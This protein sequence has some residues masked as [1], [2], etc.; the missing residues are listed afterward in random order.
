MN[1]TLKS[2]Q[3]APKPVDPSDL[4]DMQTLILRGYSWLTAASYIFL[5]IEDV[6]HAKKYLMEILPNI[7]SGRVN[8]KDI[9]QGASD[10]AIHIAFSSSGLRK[11]LPD[12]IMQTFSREFLEGMTYP[13]EKNNTTY[14]RSALLGD[15]RC[16]D[17]KR[18][19]WGNQES[20]VDCVLM[21]YAR[22]T[23]NLVKFKKEV[24]DDKK[25]GVSEVYT[26]DTFEFNP[27]NL[28]EHFGFMDGISQP[29]LRRIDEVDEFN[30]SQ[31]LN[32][33]EVILGYENE[34]NNFSPSPY[35]EGD[36]STNLP[37]ARGDSKRKDLGRNGTYLVFRQMEQHVEKFWRYQLDNSKEPGASQNERAIKLASKMVGRW[38]EGQPLVKCPDAPFND[39]SVDL[40]DFGYARDDR[41]GIRCPFGAHIRRTNPRDQVHTGNPGQLS[42]DLSKKHRM[43]RRGRLYGE[44][45]DKD[46]NVETIIE[47]VKQAPRP[48]KGENCKPEENGHM[49]P[50]P[51]VRG[52]HFIC[53]VS[54]IGRQFEF[55]QNVWANT[56]TFA[57]LCDQVDPLISPRTTDGQP[58]C[59]EFTTPQK[60][61]RN[62]YQNVPEFT[63]VV[64]GGYFFMP[65]IKALNYILNSKK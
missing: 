38:P 30:T 63:T 27:D 34:Y 54:D 26:G 23:A 20:P 1:N 58:H 17:P 42:T 16:N 28:K 7:K 51:I 21:L 9:K 3:K 32:P 14:E 33:G 64:G 31:L 11:F 2:K 37:P 62:R 13:G 12:R 40:N 15:T 24:F 25:K 50:I 56:G 29:V 61:V 59:H 57:G 44:P 5:T 48:K 52:L 39:P 55:V 45:L 47:K 18:W 41:Y 60:M 43:L 46:F 10:N 53:M 4:S 19:R 65:G 22:D 6:V 8:R 35:I 36:D 49:E